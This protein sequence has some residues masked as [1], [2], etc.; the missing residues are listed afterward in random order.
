GRHSR[1][2]ERMRRGRGGRRAGGSVRKPDGGQGRSTR[3]AGRK[4]EDASGAH[5]AGHSFANKPP[6]TRLQAWQD[7]P[8]VDLTLLAVWHKMM[9]TRAARRESP[10]N[11]S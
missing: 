5:R 2:T 7:P 9:K 8:V 10:S 4:A 11:S 6:E 1:R 3:A